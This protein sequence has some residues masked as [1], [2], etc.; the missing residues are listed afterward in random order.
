MEYIR[1][2]E[3][4]SDRLDVITESNRLIERV[5]KLLS[6]LSSLA[7]KYA[8]VPVPLDEK[9]PAPFGYLLLALCQGFLSDVG[10]LEDTKRRAAVSPVCGGPIGCSEPSERK[11]IAL[12][13]GI[14]SVSRNCLAGILDDDHLTD[15]ANCAK[16]IAK[17]IGICKDE[18]KKW[19]EKGYISYTISDID[20][21]YNGTDII[22]R[23]RP[24]EN[25]LK[26]LISAFE[27][28]EADTDRMRTDAERIDLKGEDLYTFLQ[29]HNCVGGVSS[30]RIAEEIGR[31]RTMITNE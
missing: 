13:N 30:E 26:E 11:E 4:L 14:F 17:H 28:M 8:D 24:L 3:K 29:S 19:S 10:R 9:T 1:D 7:E 6:L 15:L 25:A 2:Y 27:S 31:I 22:L 12:A 20:I 16:F 18:L 23:Y 5:E 21:K